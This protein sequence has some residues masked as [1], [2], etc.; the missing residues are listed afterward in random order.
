MALSKE[1]LETLNDESFN[2]AIDNL[3]KIDSINV[4]LAEKEAKKSPLVDIREEKQK[5]YNIVSDRLTQLDEKANPSEC[6]KELIDFQKRKK[7]LEELNKEIESLENE[8]KELNSRKDSIEVE[9]DISLNDN[10]PLVEAVKDEDDN[11]ERIQINLETSPIAISEKRFVEEAKN[12]IEN[13]S[14]TNSDEE[15]VFISRREDREEQAL[16]EIR[17]K[18]LEEKKNIEETIKSDDFVD[19]NHLIQN[20]ETNEIGNDNID[21]SLKLVA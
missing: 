4:S 19:I 5:E 13:K 12:V 10:I 21:N 15:K 1:F 8:I 6:K 18:L 7:E 20:K 14:R 3:D 17:N 9:S 16:N 2:I 11:N